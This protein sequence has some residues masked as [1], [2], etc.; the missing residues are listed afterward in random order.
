MKAWRALL[1]LLAFVGLCAFGISGGGG[2]GA[3]SNRAG[4]GGAVSL[5][6]GS[7]QVFNAINWGADPTGVANSAAKVQD[8]WNA[9]CD[10]SSNAPGTPLGAFADATLYLPAGEYRWERPFVMECPAPPGSFDHGWNFGGAGGGNSVINSTFMGPSVIAYPYTTAASLALSVQTG[11][12]SSN[13][14]IWPVNAQ[15]Y[16]DLD[17]VN[18]PTSGTA[19]PFGGLAQW[20]IRLF[21]RD[22][23]TAAN[24][25]IWSSMGALDTSIPRDGSSLYGNYLVG[26]GYLAVGSDAKLYGTL[27]VG[28][29]FHHLDSGATTITQGT[30]YEA[31]LNYDGSNVNLYVGP[32]GGTVTRVAQEAASGTIT[33]RNDENNILG[34]IVTQWPLMDSYM[35]YEWY[36]AMQSVEISNSAYHSGA[37]YAA[38]TA[39][40]SNTN[41]LTLFLMNNDHV[42]FPAL[43]RSGV[44]P[45]LQTETIGNTWTSFWMV[46]HQITQFDPGW[47]GSV[48]DLWISSRS[49]GLFATAA[50]VHAYNLQ[51]D[52]SNYMGIELAQAGTYLSTMDHIRFDARDIGLFFGEGIEN[53]NNLHETG[54]PGPFSI[55]TAGGQLDHVF[56]QPSHGSRAPIVV[57]TGGASPVRLNDI[58]EDSENGGS[59]PGIWLSGWD[60]PSVVSITN[61]WITP[62]NEF[63]QPIEAAVKMTSAGNNP[64]DDVSIKDSYVEYKGAV[65][66]VSGTSFLVNTQPIT[67][68][69]NHYNPP[70][71]NGNGTVPTK[72]VSNPT[73]PWRDVGR[74]LTMH[75]FESLGG[76]DGPDATVN[77]HMAACVA[78]PAACS[79]AVYQT[80]TP[81][82]AGGTPTPVATPTGGAT[83]TPS[84]TP[85]WCHVHSDGA[86]WFGDGFGC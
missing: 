20:D 1:A 36:G 60:S 3:P 64:G 68:E 47:V 71:R 45:I 50:A 35:G 54:S 9:M 62:Q 37:S 75:A 44:A 86:K 11:E 2:G 31:E 78:E 7:D 49:L 61:S 81:T 67:F 10:V 48:H 24:H 52:Y 55:V 84:P 17:E 15:R 82:P 51:V 43:T 77:P 14:L 6:R 41:G 38:D 73:W 12:F 5:Q 59:F 21:F 58:Y 16:F 42:N 39:D 13:A 53:G 46:V 72:Y 22:D 74:S 19:G 80:P 32:V 83:P 70:I 8:A 34:A 57:K 69:N 30:W 40:F 79:T 18:P 76:S 29:T 23:G 66:D 26:M 56:L 27:N 4:I 33:Q 25:T 65:V 63:G 28:G 85:V